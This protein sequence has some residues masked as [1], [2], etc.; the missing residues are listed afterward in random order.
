LRRIKDGGAISDENVAM[1]EPRLHPALAGVPHT[2]TDAQVAHHRR[3]LIREA[4]LVSVMLVLA[5][6][7]F[8]VRGPVLAT[9]ILLILAGTLIAALAIVMR[10]NENRWWLLAYGLSALIAGI[11][12][13]LWSF[14]VAITVLLLLSVPPL[15]DAAA[16]IFILGFVIWQRRKR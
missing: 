15:A 6:V 1:K 12:Q 7:T 2:L 11:T 4:V 10:G 14:G 8:S 5:L 13:L 16:N 3:F 9:D